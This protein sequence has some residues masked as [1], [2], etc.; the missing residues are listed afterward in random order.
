MKG[1][2]VR[3]ADHATCVRGAECFTAVGRVLDI[4]TGKEL[5]RVSPPKD[6][7][8]FLKATSPAQMLYER[9]PVDC[10]SGRILRHG[11]P[12]APKKD[13]GFPDGTFNLFLT[14]KGGRVLWSFDISD[15][16]HHIRGN[17]F[18]YR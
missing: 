2:G 9:R 15:S 17:Y 10:G 8:E 12:G 4:H 18:S 6:W 3:T 14:D 7:A 5:R 1:L 16:G 11:L 13:G